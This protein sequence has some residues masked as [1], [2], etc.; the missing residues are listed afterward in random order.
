MPEFD[1]KT[2]DP[3]QHVLQYE[4]SMILWQ[5]GDELMCKMF[6]QSLDGGAIKWF[7]NLPAQSIGTYHELVGEFCAHYRYNRRDRKECH[8]LFLLEIRKDESIRQFTRRFKQ[9]LADVDGA[10]DQSVIED[11]KQAYQYDQRG[12]YGSLVK[13]PPKTLEGLYNRV[14]EYA[15]V[16]DD[17]KARET[18]YVHRS[19]NHLN[20]GRKDKSK[21]RSNA[22]HNDRGE[23]R[24]N[25]QSERMEAGYQKYHDMKL[26]PLNIQLAELYEKISKDLI[27]PRPLRHVIRAN[28]ASSIKTMVTRPRIAALYKSRSSE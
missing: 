6:P 5:H 17:S 13:R 25:Y 3:D 2:D 11:Y 18:R 26:T 14:E 8:D 12:I 19:S 9:E 10:N 1:E 21:N 22:Q 23:V 15:R 7:N 28:T 4:T 27:P 24:E 16:E 20:D